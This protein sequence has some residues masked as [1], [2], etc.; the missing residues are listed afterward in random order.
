MCATQKLLCLNLDVYFVSSEAF[1]LQGSFGCVPLP[2]M[3][4]A[5]GADPCRWGCQ[6]GQPLQRL[7]PVQLTSASL[8]FD[9]TT[10]GQIRKKPLIK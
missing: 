6:A 9:T 2:P 7:K 4:G 5:M 8:R 1:C 10:C 3:G